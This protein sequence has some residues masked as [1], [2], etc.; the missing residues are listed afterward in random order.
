MGVMAL[1]QRA[2]QVQIT[3]MMP[4]TTPLRRLPTALFVEF[5]DGVV[6]HAQVLDAEQVALRARAPVGKA[7]R[8]RLPEP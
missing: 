7:R 4:G 2:L 6:E 3:P 1:S 8:W 5:T